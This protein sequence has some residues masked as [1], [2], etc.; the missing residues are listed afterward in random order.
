[1]KSLSGGLMWFDYATLEKSN[2]RF[3]RLGKNFNKKLSIDFILD[4]GVMKMI[5]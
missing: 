3:L 4:I 2:D 1:M 5:S